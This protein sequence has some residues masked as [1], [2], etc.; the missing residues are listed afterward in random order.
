MRPAST[1]EKIKNL[2]DQGQQVAAG[3]EDVVGV[4]GLFL[5]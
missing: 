5:V 3:G 2:I 1:L 4:L